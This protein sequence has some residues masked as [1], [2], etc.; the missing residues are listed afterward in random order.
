MILL[1]PLISIDCNAQKERS[2]L[3]I[4]DHA[5]AEPKVSYK[6]NR[7]YDNKGNLVQYDSVY[8]WS[9]SSKAGTVNA[10]SIFHSFNKQ[11]SGNFGHCIWPDSSLFNDLSGKDFFMHNWQ[12]GISHMQKMMQRMDSVNSL[13]FDRNFIKPKEEQTK[14]NSRML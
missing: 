4:N 13:F 14:M 2:T 10:D 11:F 3:K 9:Y 6:V 12:S 7:K 8:S 1:L 5:N